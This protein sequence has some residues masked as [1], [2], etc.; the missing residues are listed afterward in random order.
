M[1]TVDAMREVAHC[2]Q[3]AVRGLRS[4]HRLDMVRG[5][6]KA[7]SIDGALYNDDGYRKLAEYL[8]ADSLFQV[9]TQYE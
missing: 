3:G 5:G 6:L 8:S 9:P 2:Q 1:F 7:L 4:P